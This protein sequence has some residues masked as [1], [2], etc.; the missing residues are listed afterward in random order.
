MQTTEW[1]RRD[2]EQP[3]KPHNGVEQSRPVKG[4]RGNKVW[5]KSRDVFRVGHVRLEG[6]R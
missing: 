3:G 5:R 2:N 4:S 6:K 1:K